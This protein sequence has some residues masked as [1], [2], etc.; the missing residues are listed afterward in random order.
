P[1]KVID[2]F[3]HLF[4]FISNFNKFHMIHLKKLYDYVSENTPIIR[5]CSTS[6]VWLRTVAMFIFFAAATW[7]WIIPA[8]ILS[9]HIRFPG[10]FLLLLVAAGYCLRVFHNF[11]SLQVIAYFR[12]HDIFGNFFFNLNNHFLKHLESFCLIF[13]QWIILSI[14]TQVNTLTQLVHLVDMIHPFG[15][16]RTQ[17]D[18][19]LKFTHLFRRQFLFFLVIAHFDFFQNKVND[20]FWLFAF[21]IIYCNIIRIQQVAMN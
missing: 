17:Y 11:L 16:N 5:E 14:C 18:Y 21:N 3:C 13:L 9:L 12:L 20:F 4:K 19:F 10:L 7:A 8:D 15:I 1:P 6:V 2:S